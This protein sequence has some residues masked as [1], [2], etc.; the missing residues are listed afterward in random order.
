MKFNLDTRGAS[1]CSAIC[2]HLAVLALAVRA[3]LA[4]LGDSLGQATRSDKLLLSCR[5]SLFRAAVAV[6]AFALLAFGSVDLHPVRSCE[7]ACFPAF[8]VLERSFR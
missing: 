2:S 7:I 1:L 4:S 6:L 8:S 5:L 3:H